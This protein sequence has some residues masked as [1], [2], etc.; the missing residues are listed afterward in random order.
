VQRFA[1]IVGL[2]MAVMLS[3]LGCGSADRPASQSQQPPSSDIAFSSGGSLYAIAPDG[4][5][6]VRLTRPVTGPG[7]MGG[8]ADP[9]WS[10]DATMLAFVRSDPPSETSRTRIFLL[11]PD[12]GRPRLFTTV[13]EAFSPAWSPDGRRI[14]FVR[15]TDT[16]SA[17]VVAE[18]ESRAEQVLLREPYDPDSR[19]SFDAP[20]WSPDGTRIAYTRWTLG[21][22]FT[23]RPRLYLIDPNGG[24]ARPL[25][26]DAADAAWAPDGRRIAFAS[27][28]DRNGKRCWDQ[29]H[30]FAELYVMIADGTG[31]KRLTRNPGDDHAP[32]W[33]PDGRRIAF[34]SDRNYPDGFNHELYSIRPDGSCLTWLT[35]GTPASDDPDWRNAPG[36]SSRPRGCGPTPLPPRVAV[37]TRQVRAVDH[38]VFWLGTHDRGLLLSHTEAIRGGRSAGAVYLHYEDC[39]RF[40]PRGCPR[41][42][43]LQEVSVCS[44]H[45]SSTLGVVDAPEWAGHVRAFAAHGLLV[46]DIDDGLGVVAGSTHIRLFGELGGARGRRQL[47]NTARRLHQIGR[48]RT[49]LPAPTLPRALLRKLHRTERAYAQLGSIDAAVQRLGVSRRLVALR[50]EFARA[51]RALP[52]VR[53]IACPRR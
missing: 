42:L 19:V 11:N 22:K 21:R 33:S 48:P 17:L 15:R 9:A 36:S 5:T 6:R 13:G 43:Q 50:L 49:A 2:G 24:P 23:F 29:C 18:V 53:T 28:R 8:D 31:L 20:A 37:D 41:P 38:P 1:L 12:G 34:A 4:S 16:E 27:V 10:P 35:N 47:I 26:P 30:L 25:A 51:V 44:R 45:G 3:L 14:A 7:G 52:R 40:R 32:S 39:G 46:V